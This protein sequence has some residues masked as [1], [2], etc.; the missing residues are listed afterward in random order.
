MDGGMGTPE[1][2][3]VHVVPA[4]DLIAHEDEDC[5]C[6]PTPRFVTGAVIYVHHALDGREL[7]EFDGGV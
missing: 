4:L 2:D 7:R 1:T 3:D 5:V 6:G